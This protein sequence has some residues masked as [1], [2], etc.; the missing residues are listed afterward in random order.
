MAHTGAVIRWKA[1]SIG[2]VATVY[3]YDSRGSV[4]QV[5]TLHVNGKL[6]GEMLTAYEQARG[7]AAQLE[8]PW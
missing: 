6:L 8:F 4:S 3:S 2:V 5:V 7:D 1:D